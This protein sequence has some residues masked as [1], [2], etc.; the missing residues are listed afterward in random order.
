MLLCATGRA[1]EHDVPPAAREQEAEERVS[2]S[3]SN[4]AGLVVAP[5]VTAAFPEVSGFAN[6]LVSEA[7]VHV[8]G[9][10]WLRLR[11]PVG[12]VALDLPAGAQEPEAALGNLELGLEHR[13]PLEPSTRLELLAALVVPS[14]EHGPEMSL[15]NNRALALV[16]AL[17][18]GKDSALL[19]PGVTGLRLGVGAEHSLQRL[20]LRANLELPVLVRVSD[21]SLP[22][23]T[24]THPVGLL[25]ALELEAAYRITSWFGAS[26]GAALVT[27]PLR[28][29]EPAL[30]R[31]RSR[32][33]Q[34]VVEPALN[35]QLGRHV[36]LVLDA[37][38][39]LGGNLGG[40]AW[41]IGTHA[42]FGF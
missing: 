25:P 11:V 39:P 5:F 4:R 12:F 9:V 38:V 26:L 40:D 15:F 22:E 36:A 42:R 13:I 17:N 20:E 23:D 8:S 29:Q 2:F 7:A 10:G 28:V 37:S 3:L 6:L 34:P 30:E 18:A 16:N 19:T 1:A 24:E 14:A 35:A 32:R 31:D 33:V 21:A 27:E 41:S